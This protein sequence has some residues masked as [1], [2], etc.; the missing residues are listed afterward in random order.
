MDIHA[1]TRPRNFDSATLAGVADRRSLSTI[2][3]RER[4]S[5]RLVRRA[6]ST[7]VLATGNGIRNGYGL[8]LFAQR[9]ILRTRAQYSALGEFRFVQW[10]I[11]LAEPQ[12]IN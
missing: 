10:V 8:H 6:L 2:G 7:R 5:S 11:P 9:G 1:L 12:H 4:E 3:F